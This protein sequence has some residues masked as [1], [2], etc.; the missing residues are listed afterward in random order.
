MTNEQLRMQMLAG[1]ITESQ[2]KLQLNEGQVKTLDAST[3]KITG[4]QDITPGALKKGMIIA[5]NKS[6]SNKEELKDY[7]GE[8]TRIDADN[9]IFWKTPDGKETGWSEPSDL[10]I[11]TNL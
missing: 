2:Y 5:K 6:Y 8:F 10:V 4:D 3:M 7:A 1:I 11:V 9:N